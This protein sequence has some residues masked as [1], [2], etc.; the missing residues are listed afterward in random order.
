MFTDTRTAT[1]CERERARFPTRPRGETHGSR[2]HI[3]ANAVNRWATNTT[4]AEEARL[5]SETN[6]IQTTASHSDLNTT[7]GGSSKS[8][9]RRC[10]R[11][12]PLLL[13]APLF[14]LFLIL[15]TH[16]WSCFPSLRLHTDTP[17]SSVCVSVLLSVCQC[18]CL[19]VC[20]R[21]L[22]VAARLPLFS[23]RCVLHTLVNVTAPLTVMWP[24][25]PL[26]LAGRGAG[27]VGGGKDGR[28]EGSAVSR[29][30]GEERVDVSQQW[31]TNHEAGKYSNTAIKTIA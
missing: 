17:A 3:P 14:L 2:I 10:L 13:S 16:K 19:C 23:G 15:L 18:V 9:H 29:V 7:D 8:K 30:E 27:G 11:S 28:G 24:H 31:N 6:S 12:A 22:W 1:Y 25:G 26:S 5:T 4:W 20:A 21:R